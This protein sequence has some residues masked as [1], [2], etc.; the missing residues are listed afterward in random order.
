VDVAE[1][2]NPI[3]DTAKRPVSDEWGIYDPQRAGM[4]AVFRQLSTQEDAEPQHHL[5]ARPAAPAK[6]SNPTNSSK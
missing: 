4:A 3:P 2:K 1:A 6:P 5:K